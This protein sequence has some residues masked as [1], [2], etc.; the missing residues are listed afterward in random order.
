MIVGVGG[1]FLLAPLRDGHGRVVLGLVGD[2]VVEGDVRGHGERVGGL[3][4]ALDFLP[5]QR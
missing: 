1:V 4:Q 3:E 2:Q 5:I